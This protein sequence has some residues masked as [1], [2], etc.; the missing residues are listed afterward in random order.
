MQRTDMLDIVSKILEENLDVSLYRIL[1]RGYGG[2]LEDF[3]K[4]GVEKD[5]LIGKL[6]INAMNYGFD[7]QVKSLLKKLLKFYK[8]L[9][10]GNSS[11]KN[12]PKLR[13]EYNK[14]KEEAKKADVL[15]N[16]F[17]FKK[18][19]VDYVDAAIQKTKRLK[20]PELEMFA[21]GLDDI[22]DKSK[23]ALET[24]KKEMVK[25]VDWASEEAL[26]LA[27]KTLGCIKVWGNYHIVNSV[28][29]LI[30][31]GD[32]VIVPLTE[33]TEVV[34]K[35]AKKVNGVSTK[36]PRCNEQ[37]VAVLEWTNDQLM[38]WCAAK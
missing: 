21:E 32:E 1:V 20:D 4:N 26:S 14:L 6:T 22:L 12:F 7:G 24:L 33:A 16:G 37:S 34:K 5:D 36:N 3:V 28:T 17:L 8:S 23:A 2:C 27:V 35:W 38:V 30:K 9:Y 19:M 15:K 13:D 11:S 18:I 25:V 10:S 31:P 29:S